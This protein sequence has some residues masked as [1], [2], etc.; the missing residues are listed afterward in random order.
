MACIWVRVRQCPLRSGA[1]RLRSASATA[2]RRSRL[3][4]GS[5]HLDLALT[6]DAICSSQLGP[7][8]AQCDL[9]CEEEG[10]K[11]GRQERQEGRKAGRQ[12]GR[13]EGRKEAEKS[14]YKI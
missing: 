14:S 4:S 5:A 1:P 8:S 6:I 9:E 2:I 13:E 10:R 12:E 3:R 11:E 7:G